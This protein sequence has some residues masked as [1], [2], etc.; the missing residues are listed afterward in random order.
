MAQFERLDPERFR[1]Y[2]LT[3]VRGALAHARMSAIEFNHETVGTH[4]LLL[5]LSRHHMIRPILHEAGLPPRAGVKDEISKVFGIGKKAVENPDET[6]EYSKV[7]NA[8]IAEAIE[9]GSPRVH[10]LDLLAAISKDEKSLGF[11]IM[12]ELGISSEKLLTLI[13]S[14]LS[15]SILHKS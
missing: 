10:L 11:I 14:S 6:Y 9:R 15:R 3:P 12:K 1:V 2:R 13:E 7:V 5:V 4:H 8:A